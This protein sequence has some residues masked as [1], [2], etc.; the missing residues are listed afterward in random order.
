ML[1]EG[2]EK[3]KEKQ[4]KESA[5][6]TTAE[7]SSS[8]S[9]GHQEPTQQSNKSLATPTPTANAEPTQTAR[10][11]AHDDAKLARETDKTLVK[12]DGMQNLIDFAVNFG[13]ANLETAMNSI[14]SGEIEGRTL[15]EEEAGQVM[16]GLHRLSVAGIDPGKFK[17]YHIRMNADRSIVRSGAA[18]GQPEQVNSFD[19]DQILHSLEKEGSIKWMNFEQP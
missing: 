3:Q 8:T 12:R 6:S 19:P 11:N 16:A 1:R 2:K 14:K 10:G 15:T 17:R 5:N 9:E 13:I 7:N 18:R 4:Q